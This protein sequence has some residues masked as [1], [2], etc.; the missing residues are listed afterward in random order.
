MKLSLYFK[1]ETVSLL[2]AWWVTFARY[3]IAVYDSNHLNPNPNPF[4]PFTPRNS[5]TPSP[6]ITP[7]APHST[8]FPSFNPPHPNPKPNPNPNP[9]PN[10]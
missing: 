4:H 10:S 7:S 5:L 3:C 1:Y 9:N 6:P 8:P 2:L